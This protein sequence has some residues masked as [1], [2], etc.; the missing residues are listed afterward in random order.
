M[1]TTDE[2]AKSWQESLAARTGRAVRKA[3]ESAGL[4]AAQLSD[5]TRD[6]G[7]PIHRIA[8][9]KIENGA[10]VGKL[11]VAELVVLARA[12]EVPP[13]ELIYPDLPDGPVEVWPD[14]QTTNFQAVQWF[15]GETTADDIVPG[16]G[17][18]RG[19][20]ERLRLSRERER[21]RELRSGMGDAW[22]S[23]N[24]RSETEHRLRNEEIE[25]IHQMTKGLDRLR[26]V[27]EQG[28]SIWGAGHHDLAEIEDRMRRAGMVVG[29]GDGDEA[30]R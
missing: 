20:N 12:L 26:A 28:G 2:N 6:I 3:R 13:V 1:P 24:V 4:T 9:S 16:T 21:A 15:S 27:R 5:R 18:S 8:I 19:G 7:Y 30:T 10:R 25:A 29:D 17:E 22:Y 14:Q 23:A 11:D